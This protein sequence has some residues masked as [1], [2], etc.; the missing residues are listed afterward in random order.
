MVGSTSTLVNEVIL[1]NELIIECV[2]TW[3][4]R[5]F[6]I[7]KKISFL[8]FFFLPSFNYLIE[9]YT[10]HIWYVTKIVLSLILK[11]LVTSSSIFTTSSTKFLT[12]N[13]YMIS[14]FDVNKKL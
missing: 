1:I 14:T 10:K 13:K 2:E 8:M 7:L 9:K 11:I 4:E 6:H 3:N 5:S 12:L